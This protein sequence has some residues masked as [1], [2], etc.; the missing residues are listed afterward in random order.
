VQ[1]TGELFKKGGEEIKKEYIY[2]KGKERLL[3]IF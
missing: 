3:K 1:V 2:D